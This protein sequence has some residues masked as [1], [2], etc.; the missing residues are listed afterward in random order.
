MGTPA[1]ACNVPPD[2]GKEG[3]MPGQAAL[4]HHRV[5]GPLQHFDLESRPAFLHRLEARQ[6]GIR[7]AD[8]RKRGDAH[9]RDLGRRETMSAR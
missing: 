4:V 7:A 2:R 6:R 1:S 5:R 9:L 8:H 3:R